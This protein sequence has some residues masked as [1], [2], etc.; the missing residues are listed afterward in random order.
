MGSRE[1]EQ[2]P[3]AGSGELSSGPA[4][5]ERA[6]RHPGQTP[7]RESERL[8]CS[9]GERMGPGRASESQSGTR[10]PAGGSEP[11]RVG[12]RGTEDGHQESTVFMR[13]KKSGQRQRSHSHDGGRPKNAAPP[14]HPH[15][16]GWA[17][18]LSSTPVQL[19]PHTGWHKTSVP[20]GGAYRH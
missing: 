17:R 2:I 4:V 1:E 9:L 10:G 20:F 6:V 12:R 15:A 5:L 19:G 11:R 13:T 14:T 7:L 3:G 16:A 8:V 18:G